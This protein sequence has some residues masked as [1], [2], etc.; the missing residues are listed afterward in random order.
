M[1][2]PLRFAQINQALGAN[3][4]RPG[5]TPGGSGFG[6]RLAAFSMSAVTSSSSASSS[7]SSSRSLGSQAVSA[8]FAEESGGGDDKIH[9]LVNEGPASGDLSVELVKSENRQLMML[10]MQMQE[11]NMRDDAMS[12]VAKTRHDTKK[13][14]VSNIR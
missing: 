5:Q 1:P 2:T 10:Q 3:A 12:N 11:M 8:M 6:S 13:N 9:S 7:S 14:S 4:P